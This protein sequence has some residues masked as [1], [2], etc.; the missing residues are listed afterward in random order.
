MDMKRTKK[1]AL[2]LRR[3]KSKTDPTPSGGNTPR[4]RTA[5]AKE[6][7]AKAA[8]EALEAVAKA[9]AAAEAVAAAEREVLDVAPIEVEHAPP[10]TTAATRRNLYWIYKL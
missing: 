9:S 3:K 6:A 7:V 1:S 10:S 5:I 8:R 2:K 4:T